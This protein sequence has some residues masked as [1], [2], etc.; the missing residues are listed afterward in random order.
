VEAALTTKVVV[1]AA[2]RGT[3]M[4]AAGA[5]DISKE[6][7][8]VADSG[9]KAMIP[10]G[11]PFLD[12]ALSACADAGLTD[13]CLIVGPGA[14]ATREYYERVDTRR[15][16]IRFAVQAQPLGVANAVLAARDFV[17]DDSFVV[18]NGDN[19]YPPSVLAALRCAQG[20]A[21]A[22]FSRAGLLRDGQ[23]AAERIA[24]YALLEIDADGV[25]RRI[26]EK[27]TAAEAEAMAGAPVSMNCWL[28]D[29]RIFEACER[30][31]KSARGE[32]ELPSAVQLGIDAMRMRFQTLPV[33]AGVL[34]LSRRGDIPEVAR[35]LR[36]VRVEL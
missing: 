12:Y 23:I 9:E 3:R 24:A 21:L 36:W 15:L 20:P 31:P 2:G 34:D 32:F 5:A 10:I 17:G 1:L 14:S 30:A 8:A 29:P 4:R 28:F 7:A 18:V 35:R 26:V 16:Q 19:Y 22:A 25:L 33:D 6:Q 27:P 11:R 13:I